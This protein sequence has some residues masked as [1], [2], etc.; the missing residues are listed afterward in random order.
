MRDDEDAPEGAR[1]PRDQGGR[2]VGEKGGELR[3]ECASLPSLK[4]AQR[5]CRRASMGRVLVQRTTRLS[6]RL[7]SSLVLLPLT[8][9]RSSQPKYTRSSSP[10]PMCVPLPSHSVLPALADS[11]L[12]VLLL[13]AR[14]PTSAVDLQV[15]RRAHLSLLLHT[16][17][18][19]ADS[20]EPCR[21]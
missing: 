4:G 12:L 15:Q 7:A 16:R 13:I 17:T 1:R 3:L 2:R 6:E 10:W 14:S 8:R 19:R 18:A 21:K 20:I 5:R 9:T 11:S